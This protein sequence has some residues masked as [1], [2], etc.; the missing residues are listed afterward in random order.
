MESQIQ[1]TSAYDGDITII[2]FSNRTG[3]ERKLMKRFV[4]FHWDHYRGNPQYVP[5]LDYEYLGLK[6][7][8]ITGFFE[9]NNLF[10]RHAEIRFFIAYRGENMVG[11]TVAFVNHD[12][13]ERW[14]DN[15]GFFGQFESIED[16]IVTNALLASARTWLLSK[17]MD[18]IRG[19]QNFPVNEATPGVMTEGFESRPVIYYHYNKPYYADLMLGAGMKS[20]KRVF[21]WEVAVNNPFEEKLI[22]VAQKVISRFEVT[23]EGLDD[24][25]FAE[26]KRE[27][28][29]VYN[30]AWS[31]NFGFVPFR[32]E[33]FYSILDDMKMIMDKDLYIF[34]YVRGE[35]AAF[36][37]GVPNIFE[38]MT[39]HPKGR[40]IELLRAAKVILPF[41]RTKGYRLGYLGV[42]RKFRRIGL[43][44]VMLWKQ[45][46]FS[47]K[48]G[49]EYSDMGWVLEGNAATI[50]LVNFMSA[51]PSKT[52][53]IFE[54]KIE[55]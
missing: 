2:E 14:N 42:K 5:L 52:Y 54:Q 53:T 19:P 25:P 33:E 30:D 40:H 43:D 27:M 44:G 28:L 32:E 51:V 49:Y 23:I 34:L 37:G 38:R 21:S 36:F 12:H 39:P 1:T 9:S 6:I 13:N 11:R 50:N 29:E 4:D 46:I 45:K 15:V 31:D 20:I 8:G 47:Q 3:E 55:Q 48:A 10:Y 41:G 26:R 35:L 17:G 18:T 22:R 24:R 7:A 16:Q